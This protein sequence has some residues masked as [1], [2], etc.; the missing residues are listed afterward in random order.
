MFR[1][2][3]RLYVNGRDRSKLVA[4]MHKQVDVV[5]NVLGDEFVDVPITGVLCFVGCEWKLFKKP[6]K[7][8]GVTAI[9]PAGLTEL[10]V[11]AGNHAEAVD[12]IAARLDTA[13]RRA[14]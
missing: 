2:D 5:R 3:Y 9:W 4:G 10:V 6:L 8:D 1:A 7:I 14:S 11:R 13:L 12:S